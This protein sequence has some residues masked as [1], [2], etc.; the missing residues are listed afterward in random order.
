ML[1]LECGVV[2][3]ILRRS[4]IFFEHVLLRC[5]VLDPHVSMGQSSIR[6]R[7]ICVIE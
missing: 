1:A 6:G 7:L 3:G 5:L 2:N 4:A